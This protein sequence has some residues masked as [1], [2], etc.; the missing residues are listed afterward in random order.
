VVTRQLKVERR[1]GS[2]RRSKTGVPPTVLRNQRVCVHYPSTSLHD[3]R[4]LS[5]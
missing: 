2:V 3:R 5:R 1:T 4:T